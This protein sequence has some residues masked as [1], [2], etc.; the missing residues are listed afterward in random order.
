MQITKGAQDS[1][2]PTTFIP[3]HT[4]VG[5]NSLGFSLP[6]SFGQEG[7]RRARIYQ[8]SNANLTQNAK[9][10]Q[11]DIPPG[12]CK[13]G[14]AHLCRQIAPCA[15]L[16]NSANQD[17]TVLRTTLEREILLHEPASDGAI[18]AATNLSHYSIRHRPLSYH[19]YFPLRSHLANLAPQIAW[20]RSARVP[21]QRVPGLHQSSIATM[22]TQRNTQT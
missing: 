14:R 2:L 16:S 7:E 21:W 5:N 6:P 1:S 4:L 12:V 11:V 8:R 13:A 17:S 19:G 15:F 22:C 20:K 18:L 10:N 3:R 9:A